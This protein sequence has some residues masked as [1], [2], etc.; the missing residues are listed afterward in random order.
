MQ[1]DTRSDSP[2]RDRAV[3]FLTNQAQKIHSHV[4]STLAVRAQDDPFSKVKKLISD[5]IVR[6]QEEANQEAEHKGWCDTELATNEMTRKKKT[7][8]VEN[9]HADIDELDASVA[10]LTKDVSDL[11]QQ[12]AEL[13]AAMKKATEIRTKEREVNTQTIKDAQEAQVAVSQ[14]L[15]VLKDFYAKAG[16]ATSFTQQ[17]PEAPEIFSAPYQGMQSENGGV[18][19]MLEVIQSDFAR[20]E[21]ETK[22]SESTNQAAYDK[23][24][25]D[26]AVDKAQKNKDI[27]HKTNK[28]LDQSNTLTIKKEDLAST[29]K[30]LDAALRYF[31]KLKPSCVNAGVTYED[32]VKRRQEELESLQEALKILNGEEI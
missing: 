3:A 32:R 6:L 5:L 21:T 28:K 15:Q 12:V 16:Q 19:G 22:T 10:K 31:D 23:F 27:E 4:L 2:A 8:D 9:L 13:D 17:Q 18:I 11:T 1:L 14:A 30:E 25:S 26:T 29:Q 20:L 7:Q 24:K